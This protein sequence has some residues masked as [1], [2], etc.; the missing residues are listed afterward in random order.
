MSA[1]QPQ[2]RKAPDGPIAELAAT[3]G[4]FLT[5]SGTVTHSSF[6]PGFQPGL[7][8]RRLVVEDHGV[9]VKTI[10]GNGWASEVR[11]GDTVTLRGPI[12]GYEIGP[13][14][15]IIV[16]ER[17]RPIHRAQPNDGPGSVEHPVPNWPPATRVGARRRFRSRR[18]SLLRPLKA[19][20]AE[21]P[22]KDSHDQ[23]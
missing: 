22:S 8:N 5:F 18:D 7:T 13:T 21:R 2:D 11:E 4:T 1:T 9:R 6:M 17:T 14:G 16:L 20:K 23:N 15:L 3:I 10:V 19:K 12:K